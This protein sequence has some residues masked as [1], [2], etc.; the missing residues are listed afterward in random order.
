MREDQNRK[1]PLRRLDGLFSASS[2]EKV[3]AFAEN[4]RIITAHGAEINLYL[5]AARLA[6]FQVEPRMLAERLA[7]VL[8]QQGG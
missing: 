6:P 8:H 2:A 5:R 7:S 1:P 3:L 4:S